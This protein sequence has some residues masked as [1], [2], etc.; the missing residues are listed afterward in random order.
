MVGRLGR[1]QVDDA[2]RRVAAVKRALRAAQDFDLAQIIEFLLEEMIAQEGNVV[3][4]NRHRRIGGHRNGLRADTADLDVVAGEIGF[5]K[6]QVR[7]VLDEI[8]TAL[9][10]AWPSLL[11][12][13]RG[14]RDGHGLNVGCASLED[15]TVTVSTDVRGAGV[16]CAS[17]S[18]VISPSSLD[19][20]LGT[21]ADGAGRGVDGFEAGCRRADEECGIRAHVSSCTPLVRTPFTRIGGNQK[22]RAGLVRIDVERTFEI[23]P[24]EY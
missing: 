13:H 10:S 16:A 23:A 15:V 4:G 22:L 6:G 12:A 8:R 24:P 5:G 14:D 18:W 17:W 3:E 21:R 7:H 2:R 9:P 20:V 19:A 11:L 1:E